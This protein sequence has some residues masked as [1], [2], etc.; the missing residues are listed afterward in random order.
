[1]KSKKGF[2]IVISVIA[3]VLLLVILR[4]GGNQFKPDARKWAEA[5][6]SGQNFITAIQVESMPGEK[7]IIDLGGQVV[8]KDVY[9]IITIAPGAVLQ[10]DNIERIRKNLGPVIISSS[11]LS[12]SSRVWMILS[13][14]GIKELYILGGKPEVLVNEIRPDSS[15]LIP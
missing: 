7:L 13:Q 11:D 8:E 15:D 9:R 12:V 14:L 2:G 6:L 10:K 4:S 3:V 5:S 1:M